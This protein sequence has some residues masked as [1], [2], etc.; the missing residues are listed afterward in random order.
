MRGAPERRAFGRAE[1]AQLPAQR[2][3]D[4]DPG[5]PG[6]AWGFELVNIVYNI[7]MLF[8]LLVRRKIQKTYAEG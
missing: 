7:C 1:E 6:D 4:E 3:H 8:S 5:G 2:R